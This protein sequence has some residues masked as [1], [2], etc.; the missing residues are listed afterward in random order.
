[1]KVEVHLDAGYGAGIAL[2]P[3]ALVVLMGQLDA[4]DVVG[5]PSWWFIF[6]SKRTVIWTCSGFL[7]STLGT[8]T[9]DGVTPEP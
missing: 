5:I 7:Q 9:S 8:L 1:M 3:Y 2:S 6:S 4:E